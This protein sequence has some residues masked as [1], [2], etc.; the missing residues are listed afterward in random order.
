MQA[1]GMMI[2][3]TVSPPPPPSDCL[4]SP[5]LPC[6]A[7]GLT[8]VPAGGWTCLHHGDV[9]LLGRSPLPDGSV[10]YDVM[11]QLHLPRVPQDQPASSL[12]PPMPQ[13]LRPYPQ[14]RG[15][16]EARRQRVYDDLI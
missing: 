1:V 14:V 4:S 13:L 3:S 7:A 9:L 12:D 16:R 5:S 6:A 2:T 15:D 8:R 10:S 11:L